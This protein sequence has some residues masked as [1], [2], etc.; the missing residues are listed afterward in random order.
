[1]VPRQLAKELLLQADSWMESS[2][3]TRSLGECILVAER[4]WSLMVLAE[5]ETWVMGD[6]DFWRDFG[7]RMIF[8]SV[9]TLDTDN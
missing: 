7:G 1:V 4:R 8:T 2:R 3:S 6:S 5:V 9:L